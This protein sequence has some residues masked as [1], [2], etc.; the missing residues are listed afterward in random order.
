LRQ[1]VL[2]ALVERAP[3]EARLSAVQALEDALIR[4]AMREALDGVRDIERLAGKAAAGRASPR[5][6]RALGDS[7]ARLPLVHA[8]LER[9]RAAARSEGEA[10]FGK[11]VSQWDG[12]GDLCQE[13]RRVLVD[14]PPVTI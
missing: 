6:M 14:R 13:V 12:C 1:W 3:I 9:A 8:A 2:A 4:G 5:E 10:A 7:M 11:H